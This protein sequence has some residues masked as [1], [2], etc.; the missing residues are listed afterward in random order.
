MKVEPVAPTIRVRVTGIDL[1]EP[2]DVKVG[3][4]SVLILEHHLLVIKDI[5]SKN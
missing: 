2:L 3:D 5:D 1:H 4:L